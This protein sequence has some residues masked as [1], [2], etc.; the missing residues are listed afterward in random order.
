MSKE[1]LFVIFV[2]LV[3][4]LA[5]YYNFKSFVYATL[6]FGAVSL[7]FS[8]KDAVVVLVV[9]VLYLLSKGFFYL[10]GGDK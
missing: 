10:M 5:L 6:L 4:G 8:A 3:F 2:V 9:Y 1:V 7:V